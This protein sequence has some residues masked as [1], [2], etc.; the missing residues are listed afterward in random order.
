MKKILGISII[1]V[2]FVFF[3]TLKAGLF[4][5]IPQTELIRAYVSIPTS[6]NIPV[7]IPTTTNQI[8]YVSREF[9]WGSL[10]QNENFWMTFASLVPILINIIIPLIQY[11]RSR[12]VSQKEDHGK[13]EVQSHRILLQEVQSILR[14]LRGA[15]AFMQELNERLAQFQNELDTVKMRVKLADELQ[16][17]LQNELVSLR[18]MMKVDDE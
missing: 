5:V 15:S 18:T 8:K 3:V 11:R 14:E 6:E 2:C 16:A 9:V 1:N 7:E 17:Q 13:Q 4:P 12:L 10:P